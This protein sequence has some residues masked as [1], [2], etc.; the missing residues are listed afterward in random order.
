MRTDLQTLRI[1]LSVPQKLSASETQAFQAM[2]DQLASG[3][4]IK[5]S[6]KQR[7][8]V[9]S[10]FAHH[11]L[12]KEMPPLRDIKI[13]DKSLLTPLDALNKPLRPPPP[14]RPQ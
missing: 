8:W 3:R 12:D 5:L 9:D 13:K 7:A 10:V 2:F 14:R 4:Q 1:L 11:R 6:L